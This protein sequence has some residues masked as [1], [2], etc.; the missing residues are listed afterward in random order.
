MIV[1]LAI[2]SI[3]FVTSIYDRLIRNQLNSDSNSIQSGEIILPEL[4][5]IPAGSFDMGEQDAAFRENL[6]EEEK[7]YFGMY[8]YLEMGNLQKSII[9]FSLQSQKL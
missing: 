1:I 8:L 4:V 9:A 7:K 6:G 5:L 3:P 2:M